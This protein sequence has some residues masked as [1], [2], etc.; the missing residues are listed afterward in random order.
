MFLRE[1]AV[2]YGNS[3]SMTLETMRDLA[4]IQRRLQKLDSATA[5]LRQAI[6]GYTEMLGPDHPETLATTNELAL[7]LAHSGPAFSSSSDK[8]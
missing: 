1:K 3:H 7:L 6:A 8:I 2:A 5:L 4:S